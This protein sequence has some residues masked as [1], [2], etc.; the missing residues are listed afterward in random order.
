MDFATRYTIEGSDD[1]RIMQQVSLAGAQLKAQV[2]RLMQS[3]DGN[4]MA[5]LRAELTDSLQAYKERM[6]ELILQAP[7]SPVA[8]FIV[9]QQVNGMPIFNTFD[10]ADNRIIAAV[11]TAHD[12]YA[13]GE[14]RTEYIHDL[15]LQGIAALRAERKEAQRIDTDTLP[16]TDF[17]DIA[18]YDMQGH[19]RRLSDITKQ[20]RAVLLDFTAYGYEY[21]PEYNM[22]L[23]SLYKKYHRE[24]TM[25]NCIFKALR[26]E[27]GNEI[28]NVLVKK[29]LL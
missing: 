2:N 5:I 15:A 24:T 22:L 20:H 21:S 10:P 26:A 14:P 9:M 3:T 13:P 6:T 29:E 1:C 11:A 8:Y 4:D 16:E 7:S 17:I 23:A 27:L 19:E 28:V 12:I 25:L 18:L